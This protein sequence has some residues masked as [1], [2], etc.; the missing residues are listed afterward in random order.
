MKLGKKGIA[1]IISTVILIGFAVALGGVVISW[2]KVSY[3][4]EVAECGS[5]GLSDVT[6]EGS[7]LACLSADTLQLTV[8]NT[9]SD[10]LAGIKGSL[11]TDAGVEVLEI[12]GRVGA[13]ELSQLNVLLPPGMGKLNKA[14]FTPGFSDV[15]GITYCPQ[16]GFSVESLGVCEK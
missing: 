12:D 9:G 6:L 5:M 1:P 14:F 11:L 16:Q 10:S 2:G 4:V 13:G 15:A 3:T 7:S 8:Q